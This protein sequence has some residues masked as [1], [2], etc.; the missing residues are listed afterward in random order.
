MSA[1]IPAGWHVVLDLISK[2]AQV[3]GEDPGDDVSGWYQERFGGFASMSR[4]LQP[5]RLVA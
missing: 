1:G 5:R 2:V 4:S 3:L